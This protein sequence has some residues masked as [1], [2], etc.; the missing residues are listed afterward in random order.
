MGEHHILGAAVQ[1]REG[2]VKHQHRPGMGKGAG[3]RQPLALPAG[4]AGTAAADDGIGSVF[5]RRH[6]PLQ[7][8]SGQIRRSVLSLTAEDVIANG[9]GAELRVVAQSHYDWVFPV[10]SWPSPPA[11][12]RLCIRSWRIW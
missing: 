2:V 10:R 8:R 3:Q 12:S 5:H 6:L 9:I 11:S 4:Q 7:R 1:R